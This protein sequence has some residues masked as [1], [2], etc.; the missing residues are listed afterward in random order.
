MKVNIIA[1]SGYPGSGKDEFYKYYVNL[2]SNKKNLFTENLKFA[3]GIINVMSVLTGKPVTYLKKLALDA[4]RKENELLFIGPLSEG[5]TYRQLAIK[6]GE[7]FRSSF[8]Q[9]IWCSLTIQELDSHLNNLGH[10]ANIGML[11]TAINIF[12]TDL[13]RPNEYETLENYCYSNGFTFI[14]IHLIRK[15]SYLKLITK[16]ES[17]NNNCAL[18]GML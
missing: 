9:N 12:I 17:E 13:R 6:I 18:S 8:F 3:D 14:P 16:Y 1:L 11:Y 5:Y 10:L 7:E 15:Q 4:D 2:N